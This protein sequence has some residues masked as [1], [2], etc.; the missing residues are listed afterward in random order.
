M[1][2]VVLTSEI[3]MSNSILFSLRGKSRKFQNSIIWKKLPIYSTK[4]FQRNGL[5]RSH[6]WFKQ[7]DTSPWELVSLNSNFTWVAFNNSHINLCL[8]IVQTALAFLSIWQAMSTRLIAFSETRAHQRAI[9]ASNQHVKSTLPNFC[10]SLKIH[11]TLWVTSQ[12]N[13][14]LTLTRRW[15]FAYNWQIRR[16]RGTTRVQERGFRQ[17]DQRSRSDRRSTSAV[18]GVLN[19]LKNFNQHYH[20][21]VDSIGHYTAECILQL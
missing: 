11:A 12:T 7:W 4:W 5:D 19:D 15:N 16:V 9:A 1:N 13:A 18:K 6:T 8:T 21:F 10:L 14:C 3:S 2:S 17:G 20:L